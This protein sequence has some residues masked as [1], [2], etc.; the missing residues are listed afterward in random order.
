MAPM[1][2]FAD[3]MLGK[4]GRWLRALGVDVAYSIT[5]P[6]ELIITCAKREERVVLTRDQKLFKRLQILKIPVIFIK[7]DRWEDQIRQFFSEH[8]ELKSMDHALTRCMECNEPLESLPKEKVKERVWPFVYDTQ[9]S[10][11]FCRRCDKIYWKATHVEKI[12]RRLEAIVEGSKK[13]K[14]S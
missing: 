3:E 1:R 8:P 12:L 7:H 11:S 5:A 4:L 6:D 14:S 10:F 2:F 13:R 9:E